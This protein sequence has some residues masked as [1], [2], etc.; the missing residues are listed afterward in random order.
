MRL[1][2][3]TSAYLSEEKESLIDP[4]ES[5]KECTCGWVRVN[6]HYHVKMFKSFG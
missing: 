4:L 3:W 1:T 6:A 2:V 5:L